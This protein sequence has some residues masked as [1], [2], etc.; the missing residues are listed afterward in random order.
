VVSEK[1]KLEVLELDGIAP[2]VKG[3]V[4][5]EYPLLKPLY[6]ATHEGAKPLA[7]KFIEF[8]Q[9]PAGTAL[10]EKLGYTHEFR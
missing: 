3:K 7:R 6:V 10:F 2:M 4:N 5:L 8:L 9:S 1:R